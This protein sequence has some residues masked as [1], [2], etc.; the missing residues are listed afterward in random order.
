MKM[1]FNSRGSDGKHFGLQSVFRD[2]APE[3]ACRVNPRFDRV[4][5]VA[6]GILFIR[7]VSDTS[8]QAGNLA[9]PAAVL[10]VRI[11][12]DLSHRTQS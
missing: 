4:T 7:A 2:I 6:E 12:Q 3:L 5:C 10:N 9:N 11:D 8:R 1:Y